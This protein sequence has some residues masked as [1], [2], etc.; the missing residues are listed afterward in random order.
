MQSRILLS[1]ISFMILFIVIGCSSDEETKYLEGVTGEIVEIQD[2]SF[3]I[4]DNPGK[5][6]L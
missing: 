1:V 5:V 2:E 3:L 4:Q 6:D